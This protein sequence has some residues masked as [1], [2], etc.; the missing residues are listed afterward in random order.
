[1]VSLQPLRDALTRAVL[2]LGRTERLLVKV[3]RKEATLTDVWREAASANEALR[4]FDQE[5]YNLS[6]EYRKRYP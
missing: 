6:V 4:H 5:M 3:A 2:A 1:M